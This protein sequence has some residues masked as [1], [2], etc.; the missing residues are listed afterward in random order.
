MRENPKKLNKRMRER[1]KRANPP[2]GPRLSSA[3]DANEAKAFVSIA[4]EL[5]VGGSDSRQ[6]LGL[7]WQSVSGDTAFARTE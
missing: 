2:D 4:K 6:R 7:R 5:R 1:A 3:A